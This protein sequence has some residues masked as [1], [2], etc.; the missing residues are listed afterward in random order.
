MG[1][2][3]YGNHDAPP[4]G[5]GAQD[6]P[7]PE[8]GSGEESSSPAALGIRPQDKSSPDPPGG[9]G[10]DEAATAK[11]DRRNVATPGEGASRTPGGSQGDEVDPGVGKTNQSKE[12]ANERF[13]QGTRTPRPESRRPRPRTG[14]KK[15]A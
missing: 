8:G 14:R 2:A 7:G 15:P 1:N 10:P 9:G 13:Q 11:P 6:R 5:A 3:G 12:S 4:A